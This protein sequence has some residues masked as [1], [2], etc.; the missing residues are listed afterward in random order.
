DFAKSAD[1]RQVMELVYSQAVFGRPYVLP[2]G[3]PPERVSAL[4][5]AFMAALADP[6]LL[7]EAAKMKLDIEALSG[8]DVQTMVG[9]LF[10]MPARIVERAKQA[11]VYRPPPR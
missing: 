2:P 4:R 10:A 8:D 6:A 1:D 11:L 5:K 7:G 3:V 9:Q